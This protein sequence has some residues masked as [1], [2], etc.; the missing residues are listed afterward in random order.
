VP[1][2]D[3]YAVLGVP[4]DASPDE[5]KKAYR[6]LA[7]ELHPDV[8]KDPAAEERFKRV[9]HAYDVLADPEKRRIHDLGGDPFA[10]AGGM[11]GGGFAGFG[12]LGD[13]FDA[14]LGGA[15]SRGPRPRTRPG[16]D[17]LIR[18]DL[19]L[20]DAAFGATRDIAVETAMVCHTCKGAGTASGT[21][22]ATC[23]ICHGRG[24]V[25]QVSRSFLGQVVTAR[26]CPE[27]GGT[28]TVIPH[29]CPE[30]AG[31]GRVRARRTLAVKIPAGVEHGM[32]I[33]LAGEGEVGPGG[34]PPGDLY[35]EVNEL[36]HALLQRDGDDLHCTVTLPMTAAAL[37]TTVKV[38]ALDGEEELDVRPGTQAG[39]VI[40]LR[41]RGVPHLRG[42]GRGDLLVHVVV[43][44]PTK[45][46]PEQEQLMRDLARMRGEEAPPGQFAPGQQGLFS[47]IRDAWGGR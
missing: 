25:S 15:A 8:N 14:F 46:E 7:R 24:E 2:T 40:E 29:P 6:R 32:R 44:T 4:R 13:I 33:R 31:D 21:H 12:G 28:G 42:V 19:E 18:L 35:V 22:P 37:G 38:P 3:Y 30:C 27:C 16:A 9:S 43:A 23:G 20:V 1:T 26:A 11:A 34:G 10:G 41:A 39:Q 5:I 17:A 45:L 36:P 47:R